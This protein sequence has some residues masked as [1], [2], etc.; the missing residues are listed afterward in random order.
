[1]RRRP[2]FL[3]TASLL[4]YISVPMFITFLNSL[5]VFVVAV[6][7]VYLLQG[8][9]PLATRCWG[10]L[11]LEGCE[12]HSVQHTT[13]ATRNVRRNT[14]LAFLDISRAERLRNTRY[15]YSVSHPSP[16]PE[17]FWHFPKR[18]G[19]FSCLNF[20]RLLYFP[21]YAGLQIF[22]QLPPTLTKLCHIKLDHPVHIICSKMSTIGRNACWVALRRGTL[23]A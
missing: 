6:Y 2:Y 21:I 10:S 15:I 23:Q 19:I 7:S 1:M 13:V 5:S 16:H 14:L 12:P 18:L 3:A 17:L 22:I 8:L 20:T 4:F 11:Y 9:Q